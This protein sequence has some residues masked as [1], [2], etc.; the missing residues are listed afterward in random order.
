MPINSNL[1]TKKTSASFQRLAITRC[2]P[3]SLTARPDR[4]QI[5]VRETLDVFQGFELPH[6]TECSRLELR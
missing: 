2:Y 1:S 6:S 5:D 4:P 3:K